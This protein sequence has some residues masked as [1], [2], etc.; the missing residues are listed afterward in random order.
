LKRIAAAG[1]GIYEHL[2]N[3]TE[4]VVNSLVHKI[5]S[6]EQKEFG[7]NIFTDYNSYFQYFLAISL[8]LLVAEFFIPEIRRSARANVVTA[9]EKP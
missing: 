3:N 2:D 6:M 7:E 8:I 9:T 5:D 1:K 4:E